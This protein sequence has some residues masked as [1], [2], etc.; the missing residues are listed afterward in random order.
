[1]LLGIRHAVEHGSPRPKS[2]RP[3]A[4]EALETALEDPQLIKEAKIQL[5]SLERR[6]RKG[7][8]A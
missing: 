4:R 8:L 1:M 5:R 3:E 2:A 6:K 7:I